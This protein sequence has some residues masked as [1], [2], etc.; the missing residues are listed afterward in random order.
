MSFSE[1]FKKSFLDGFANTE[2]T[3]NHIII[4]LISTCL[5]ALYI[6]FVYRILVRNTFYSRSFNIAVA[7]IAVITASI[8]LTVQ[9]SIVISLGMVGA[10]SI[11]RFRTAIKD[12]MDLVFLFWSI[13]VGII[14]GAGM[15]EIAIC[16]SLV[17]TA[18]IFLL[19]QFPVARAPRILIVNT[20]NRKLEQ[21]ILLI[22]KKYCKIYQIKSRTITP[23]KL[24]MVI[25]I[26]IREEDKL[27]DEIASLEGIG[28]VSLL[29]HDGEV[30]F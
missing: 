18:G 16:T 21:D 4:V 19:N 3:L 13:S 2:I 30:T 27:V 6:F 7:A 9:S 28:T 5:I 26:R 29:N 15:V 11:V 22:V 17:L 12:P 20:R 10:L 23:D 24:D 14:C 1:I 8:I 25:E